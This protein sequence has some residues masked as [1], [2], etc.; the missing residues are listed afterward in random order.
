MTWSVLSMAGPSI[1]KIEKQ[2]SYQE[3]G[4]VV[5]IALSC[6]DPKDEKKNQLDQCSQS[7]KDTDKHAY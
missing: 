1:A 5:Q 6:L 2:R 3:K 7:S 4:K